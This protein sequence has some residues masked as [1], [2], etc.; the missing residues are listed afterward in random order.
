M[1]RKSRLTILII[2]VFALVIGCASVPMTPT[3]KY[4]VTRATFNDI[5]ENHYIPFFKLQ[6]PEV[7]QE[8]REKAVPVIQEAAGALDM[9]YWSLSIPGEDPNARLLFYM[10]LK[11]K[12]INLVAKYGL[13]IPEE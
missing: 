5:L 3:Q 12:L 8:L 13:Q 4:A 7:Q 1:N 2:M 9:Y 10:D 6:T 11:N